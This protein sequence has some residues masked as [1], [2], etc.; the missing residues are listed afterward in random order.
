MNLDK[1]SLAYI[2]NVVNTARMV[3]IDDVIIEPGKVRAIDE[4][5]TVVL[6]QDT[7]VPEMPFNS[8]GLNRIN[9]FLSRLGI[10]KTQEDFKVKRAYNRCI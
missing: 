8:I 2:T 7:D 9:V 3:D 5:K 10:A 6:F 1:Q 4:N